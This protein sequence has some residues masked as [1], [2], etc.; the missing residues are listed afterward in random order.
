MVTALTAII[1]VAL[2][3]SPGS[4]GPLSDPGHRSYLGVVQ[5]QPQS[6]S[7]ELDEA[8]TTTELVLKLYAEGKY[9]EAL[10]LAKR[11]VK[12]RET[13]LGADDPLLR[14]ALM[15]L[16]DIY[17]ALGKQG[18]AQSSLER[19]A[20]SHEKTDPVASSYSR[21]LG[22]LALVHFVKGNLSKAEESY[23]RAL[24][25]TEK[26]FGP[27][28]DSTAQAILNLAEFYQVNRNYKKGEPLYK[29]L[30][31]IQEKRSGPTQREQL[32]FAVDRYACLLRK[33][34]RT[35][36]AKGLEDRIFGPPTSK[37]NQDDA[38]GLENVL[39]GKAISMPR[40]SYP[41]QAMEAHVRGTVTVRVV[42]DETGNVVRACAISGPPLLIRESELAAYRA[43]FTPTKLSGQPVTVT[44]YITYNFGN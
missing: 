9:D 39:K 7:A 13:A 21:V 14:S 1:Q 36:D 30:V 12:L 18:D 34:N 4:N 6:Q 43:K 19:L 23:Q 41:M 2:F 37:E 38:A 3:F 20:K 27:D 5:S 24:E 35:A 42:I 29:R 17:F 25:V 33:S 22:R 10:P 40:P 8:A 44:G 15:N 32:H 16:V 28:G 31:S 26:A 11:A